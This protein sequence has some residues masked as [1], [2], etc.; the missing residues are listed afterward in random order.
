MGLDSNPVTSHEMAVFGFTEARQKH[1]LNL[2][3]TKLE[4]RAFGVFFVYTPSSKFIHVSN[5]PA[6]LQKSSGPLGA[7]ENVDEPA[8]CTTPFRVKS[9]HFITV[10]LVFFSTRSWFICFSHV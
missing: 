10:P 9:E 6:I 2:D 1:P 8:Q 5:H 4:I 3:F 7:H